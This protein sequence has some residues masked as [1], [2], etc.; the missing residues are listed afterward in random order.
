MLI[1]I[2]YLQYI[3]A[4]YNID[5]MT[6][7]YIFLAL[8]IVVILF[9]FYKQYTR[10]QRRTE[11]MTNAN[12]ICTDASNVKYTDSANLPLREYCIKSSFNSAYNGTNVS[13]EVLENRIKEGYR[14]IDLNV[15]SASGD[16][17]VGFSQD[18]T[19][20]LVSSNLKLSDAL[21][22]ISSAAFSNSTTFDSSMSE[23]ASYPVF[24]HIRVYRPANSQVDIISEVAKVVNGVPNN[25][26]QYKTHYLRNSDGTPVQISGCTPLE[27]LMPGKK[28]KIIFSMDILNILEI[29][30]P[31]D[32]QSAST[33]SPGDI[34]SIDS[35]VNVLTGG[36]TIP[37]F[38]RYTDETLISRTNKLG[39]G[40]SKSV[41]SNVKYMYISFPHPD[42][43]TDSVNRN[44]TG[45]IHP[46]LPTFLLYRSIQLTPMRVYLADDS[47]SNLKMYI[48]MFDTIGKP[49]APMTFVYQY[50]SSNTTPHH[51]NTSI[52]NKDNTGNDNS[53]K[54][55]P[56]ETAIAILTVLLLLVFGVCIA[57]YV[58]F[59]NKIKK[60]IVPFQIPI[61]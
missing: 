56:N 58:Y 57:E 28:G 54:L 22:K 40:D 12:D 29:Y 26:P 17:Y 23:V 60:S 34:A 14:F 16:V 36:S 10:G 20:T 55:I 8:S 27:Q 33:I 7:K 21:T 30:A 37:A 44:A 45:I 15:F 46:D 41:V 24:V 35:F 52:Y 11:Y 9:V 32:K 49:F 38:Y 19:P 4:A 1:R 6:L 39:L 2:I 61:A 53:S 50:L 42:D 13:A 48:N 43:T 59:S 18:N 25:P 5:K 31:I 3:F 47:N 51:I